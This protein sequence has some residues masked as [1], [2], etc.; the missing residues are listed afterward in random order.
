V[1]RRQVPSTDRLWVEHRRPLALHAFIDESGQIGVTDAASDHFVMS[2]VVCRDSNLGHLDDALAEIRQA[3]GRAPGHRVSWKRTKKHEQRLRAVQI[4]GGKQFVKTVSVVVCKR[5]LIP[6]ITDTSVAYL[7]TLRLLLERLSW[8]GA[9]HLTQTGYTL[10]HVKHFRKEKLRDYETKLREMGTD[11]RIN[12]RY[13]D[14][15]GGRI[16][17]DR[18]LQPLQLADVVASATAR[19]FEANRSGPA[20]QT[21]LRELL[22]LAY[23]GTDPNAANVLTAYGLKMHPWR[24]DMHQDYAW[25]LPLR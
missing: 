16:S 19:A 1:P 24:R 12:W 23:R 3:L 14:P 22:P 9:R 2:A 4:L 18:T 7:F 10:S 21:Y 6:P 13:L 15:Y 11:T 20:D 17:N 5:H 25:I 8:L